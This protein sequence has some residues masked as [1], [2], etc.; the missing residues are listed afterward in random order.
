MK[1]LY[2]TFDDSIVA[3]VDKGIGSSSGTG[4]LYGS[5]TAVEL[6]SV[7]GSDMSNVTMLR[8]HSLEGSTASNLQVCPDFVHLEHCGLASSHYTRTLVDVGRQSYETIR[9]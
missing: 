4:A 9:P 3:L 6:D 7:D 1:R 5:R 8:C 2:S